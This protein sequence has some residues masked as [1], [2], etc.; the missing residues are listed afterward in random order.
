MEDRYEEIYPHLSFWKV[1]SYKKCRIQEQEERCK[2]ALEIYDNRG[3]LYYD[4]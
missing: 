4:E 2:Y 1:K 3:E